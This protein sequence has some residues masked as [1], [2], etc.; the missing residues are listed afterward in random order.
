MLPDLGHQALVLSSAPLGQY[1][2]KPPEMKCKC[3]NL[4]LGFPSCYL[5]LLNYKSET[6]FDISLV[7]ARLQPVGVSG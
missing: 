2:T 3:F 1:F 6:H 5:Q 4:P 7:N